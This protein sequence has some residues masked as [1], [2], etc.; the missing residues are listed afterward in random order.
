MD[1]QAVYLKPNKRQEALNILDRYLQRSP[2]DPNRE[3]AIERARKLR[4]AL[5]PDR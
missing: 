1:V 4:A 3:L 2:D 5:S